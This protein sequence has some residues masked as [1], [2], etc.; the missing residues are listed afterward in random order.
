[1]KTNFS[2]N[3]CFFF[4]T[5]MIFK[6]DFCFSQENIGKRIDSLFTVYID[7]GFS[8]SVLVAEKSIITLKKGYGYSNTEKK[9]DNTPTTLFNVASIGKQFTAYSI[10]LLEKR[11]LLRTG[12][13]INKYIGQF[14]DVRDSTTIHHLLLHSS[15]VFRQDANLDYSTRE[16]FIS[17]IK[18]S[19]MESPPGKEYRYSNAGYTLLAAI[20][21]IVSQEPFEQFIYK[22]V[23]IPCKMENT[24]FPWETRMN[25]ILFATGYD[26]K[27]QA[28]APQADIWGTRGPGHLVTSVEDLYTWVNAFQDKKFMPADIRQKLFTDHIPGKETYSWNKNTTQRQ[29]KFYHK[30]G[31]RPDFESQLMWYPDDDVIIIFLINN[32]YNLRSKLFTRIKTIMN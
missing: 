11:G 8:G 13:R 3:V 21:E 14:N 9:T 26:N 30:G 18:Q 2:K 10:L 4:I 7:S 25:K 22:N 5:A 1:M 24:G 28:V 15:G 20:I 19:G 12:D 23:F 31:G 17:S 32:D 27:K 6:S 29:T 16:K